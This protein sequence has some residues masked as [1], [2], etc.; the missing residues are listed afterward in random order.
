MRA[1]FYTAGVGEQ[2][3]NSPDRSDEDLVRDFV[4]GDTDAYEALVRRYMKP[5]LNF[6]YR[7][8]GNRSDAD[9]LAQDVFVQ[10]YKALPRARTDLPFKPWLY[11]VARNKCLDFLKKKR[12]IHFSAF[13]N[14]ETADNPMDNVADPDPLPEEL[15][16]QADLQRLLHRAIEAL[17]EKYRVVVSLRYASGLTFAEIGETLSLPENT[18]KTQFQRA[19]ASLRSSLASLA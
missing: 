6:V 3:A 13:D 19:K 4:V 7:M 2:R 12:P 14:A 15:V 16:E 9:D 11:V 10:V 18:V 5:I 1:G 8:I 17:P